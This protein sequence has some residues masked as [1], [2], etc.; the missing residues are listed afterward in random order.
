M[1]PA[2]FVKNSLCTCGFP[3]LNENIPVGTVYQIDPDTRYLGSM[4]C[5]GCRSLLQL[6]MV[7]AAAQGESKAGFVPDGIFEY[8]RKADT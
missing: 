7:W 6:T 4:I 1:I 5:G 3:V 8:D 2:R